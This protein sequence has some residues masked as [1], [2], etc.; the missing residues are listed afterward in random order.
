MYLPAPFTHNQS[1]TICHQSPPQMKKPSLLLK[2]FT[3]TK[4]QKHSALHRSTTI[5]LW[6]RSRTRLGPPPPPPSPSPSPAPWLRLVA[7]EGLGPDSSWPVMNNA[8]LLLLLLREADRRGDLVQQR[9][10]SVQMQSGIFRL[11][12]SHPLSISLSLPPS[13]SLDHT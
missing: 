1:L 4:K 11:P 13:L 6:L 3:K 8:S 2:A 9:V 10:D 12:P 7:A 5:L